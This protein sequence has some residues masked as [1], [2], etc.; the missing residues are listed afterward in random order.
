MQ[1]HPT[2][3]LQPLNQ[4]QLAGLLMSMDAYNMQS[5]KR[6][7]WHDKSNDKDLLY[8]DISMFSVFFLKGST[9]WIIDYKVTEEQLSDPT[10]DNYIT[11]RLL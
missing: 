3:Y 1:Q 2:T 5:Y 8:L 7:Y 6:R 4:K 9:G 11:V 10:P